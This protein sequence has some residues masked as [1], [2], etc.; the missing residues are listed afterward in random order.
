MFKILKINYLLLQKISILIFYRSKKVFRIN[1]FIILNPNTFKWFIV[2]IAKNIKELK[3]NAKTLN[4]EKIKMIFQIQESILLMLLEI[5]KNLKIAWIRIVPAK[6]KILMI[7][8]DHF[9]LTRF[10][11]QKIIPFYKFKIIVN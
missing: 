9:Q 4:F 8:A 2:P 11:T 10:W 3:D 5:K 1:S 6:N 7:F